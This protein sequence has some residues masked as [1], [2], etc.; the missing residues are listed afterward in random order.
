MIQLANDRAEEMVYGNRAQTSYRRMPEFRHLEGLPDSLDVLLLPKKGTLVFRASDN[1]TVDAWLDGED[2]PLTQAYNALARKR[3]M[4]ASTEFF[5]DPDVRFPDPDITS[6]DFY[7]NFDGVSSNRRNGC[8]TERRKASPYFCYT[9]TK[10]EG[11]TYH[12]LLV[13]LGNYG[14]STQDVLDE[15]RASTKVASP[16]KAKSNAHRVESDV[17][18]PEVERVLEPVG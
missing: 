17:P 7:S 3:V 10:D 18:V 12:L 6:P 16:V 8:I 11:T 9:K 15:L 14:I 2:G 1:A 13:S 4:D 5:P